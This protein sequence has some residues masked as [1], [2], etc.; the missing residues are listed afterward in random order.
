[1]SHYNTLFAYVLELNTILT[2]TSRPLLRE[3]AITRINAKNYYE[4]CKQTRVI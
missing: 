2:H 1:M 4:V 3:E